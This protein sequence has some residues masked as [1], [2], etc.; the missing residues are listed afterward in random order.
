MSTPMNLGAIGNVFY[1]VEDYDGAVAWYSARLGRK[2]VIS[3]PQLTAFDID[4]VRLTVHRSDA[5]NTPGPAGQ[6]AYWTVEDVDSV[7]SEW[8][9]H[10]AKVHRGPK[11]V[12]TG[13]RLCQLLDPFGN[14]FSIRQVTN[15]GPIP[16]APEGTTQTVT[17]SETPEAATPNAPAPSASRGAE[18]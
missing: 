13:E 7:V 10:G 2:P 18:D 15:L 16:Q 3:A 1:F 6:S 9:A 11:T 17:Q 14:I 5:Q 8:E 12:F 4:G